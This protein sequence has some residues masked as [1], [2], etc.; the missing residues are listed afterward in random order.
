VLEAPLAE[1]L[2]V[3]EQRLGEKKKNGRAGPEIEIL[4]FDAR[5]I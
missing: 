3:L 1:L 4:E 5:G 2:L